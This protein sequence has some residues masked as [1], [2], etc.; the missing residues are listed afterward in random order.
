MRPNAA[1]SGLVFKQRPQPTKPLGSPERHGGV[2]ASVN[3]RSALIRAGDRSSE[4]IAFESE[5]VSFFLD[6]AEM[7]GI[8]K[9]VAAIYGICF[10]NPHPLSFADISERLDI[11][12]GSIS[13]GLRVLREIGAL[14]VAGTSDRREYFSP[15]LEL[16]KLAS[17][18]IEERLE[19]Q[20]KAGRGRLQSMKAVIPAAYDTSD[21]ALKARMKYLQAWHDKG[22]A[23]VP[24]LKTFLRLG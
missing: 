14:K 13:Q 2:A 7:L 17:H 24:L 21:K 23:L 10:A 19:E 11:S 22:R 16:R 5:V 1:D 8:P 6:A 20:L 4:I 12:Q 3:F 18:F 15:E 9:S